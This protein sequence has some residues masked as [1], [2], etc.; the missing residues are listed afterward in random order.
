MNNDFWVTRDAIY[1]W[2]SLVTSSLVKIIGK[3]P[4]SWPKIVIHGN[5]CIILYIF[6]AWCSIWLIVRSS[7]HVHLPSGL[8]PI[9]P[10]TISQWCIGLL[11]FTNILA[12]LLNNFIH[13]E[14]PRGIVHQFQKKTGLQPPLS[15]RT[16]HTHTKIR[17]PISIYI[18]VKWWDTIT[19]ESNH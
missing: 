4:H 8:E 10:M 17:T 9:I 18:H 5:S 12:L 1:Q 15:T 19:H 11:P 16:S 13:H 2:F 3:S 7:A 6:G 14:G